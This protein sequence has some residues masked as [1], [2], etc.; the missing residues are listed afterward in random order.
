MAERIAGTGRVTV[1]GDKGYDT[2]AFIA[3][4]RHMNIT[5]QVAQNTTRPGGS[6]IDRRTRRHAA[7]GVSQQRRK[8]VESFLV[9][10]RPSPVKKD[11]ISRTVA[12]R[13]DLYLRGRC[14]QRRADA[15]AGDRDSSSRSRIGAACPSGAKP[16]FGHS[17]SPVEYLLTS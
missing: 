6:A 11:Q 14:L 5:P 1:A 13:L 8:I 15:N 17:R 2:R 12:R 10:L 7:Y 3:E 4:L 9:G 16:P